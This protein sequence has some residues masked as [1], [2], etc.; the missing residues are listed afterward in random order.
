MARRR[1]RVRR[2]G[3]R[4]GYGAP[5]KARRLTASSTLRLLREFHRE[6]DLP[7]VKTQHFRAWLEERGYDTSNL[8]EIIKRL[9]REGKVEVPM[10]RMELKPDHRFIAHGRVWSEFQKSKGR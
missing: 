2:S 9:L 6:E 5:K 3:K 7:M 4:I 1:V 8:D 10:M